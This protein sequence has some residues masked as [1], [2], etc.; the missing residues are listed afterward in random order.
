MSS[1]LKSRI[2][3]DLNA[4]RKE[5]DKGRTLVL[6]TILSEIRNKEIDGRVDLDDEG[7]IQVVSKAIKQR[8]DAATQFR[9][10][11]RPEL[12]DQEEAQ[13]A[14]LQVYLPEALSEDDV[15]AMVREAIAG[16]ADQ[17]GAVMGALMPRIRGRFDGGEA[18]RIV[19]DELSS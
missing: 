19:R 14:V 5:R 17:M 13:A 15:R 4:A 18:N 16:G 6:G 10:A 3:A 9:D 7:V 2:Q 12:A 1:E 8:N 11:G